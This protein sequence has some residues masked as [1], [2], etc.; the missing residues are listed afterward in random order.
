MNRTVWAVAAALGVLACGGTQSAP[1]AA[2]LTQIGPYVTDGVLPAASVRCLSGGSPLAVLTAHL[3]PGRPV[4]WATVVNGVRTRA[5]SARADK[6]G[7]L[8]VPTAVPDGRRSRV[9]LQLDRRTVVNA[10]VTPHCAKAAPVPVPTAVPA[11]A[12]STGRGSTTSYTLHRNS[13]GSVTR[14]NPCAGDIHVRV[15]PTLGGAG[16]LADAQAA[17]DALSRGSGL[18]FVYDGTTTF[19]PASSRS[20]SQPAEVVIAWAPPGTGAGAS[21]Y[22][23][24]GAVGEGG[25]RSSGTSNDG[26]ATW[27]WRIVQGFV[28]LDPGSPLPGGFGAGVTRGSLLL[29]ELGHVAGLGHTDDGS[30]VMYPVLRS[31]SVG[32]FGAG[33]LT[34]LTAV[35]AANGCTTAF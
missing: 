4:S 33:D 29:H 11:A 21:D 2:A 8:T 13:N 12:A 20:A 27:N 19:V 10:V 34:G 26:G 17:L 35:G 1:A 3:R 24:P 25:W 30:Q 5:G 28:V 23:Q 7:T 6:H 31:S 16:A 9:V 14:W 22:Y 18:H 15:N 32:S